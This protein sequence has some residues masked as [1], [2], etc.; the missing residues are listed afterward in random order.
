MDEISDGNIVYDYMTMSI[1]DVDSAEKVRILFERLRLANEK[2]DYEWRD[3]HL[4][5]YEYRKERKM[6]AREFLETFGIEFSCTAVQY[7]SSYG[8]KRNI[9]R[10]PGSVGLLLLEDLKKAKNG[11]ISPTA[12]PLRNRK[13]RLSDIIL[14]ISEG[15]SKLGIEGVTVGDVDEVGSS[16]A[17]VILRANKSTHSSMTI[18]DIQKKL[19]EMLKDEGMEINVIVDCLDWFMYC[20]N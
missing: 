6:T 12:S 13:E 1:S 11:F 3:L 2:T 15:L 14:E 17:H 8:G 9:P 18:E 16:D 4:W 10:R 7:L 20:A 19:N 5:A